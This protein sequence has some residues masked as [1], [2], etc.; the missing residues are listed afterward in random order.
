MHLDVT[1]AVALV[2]ARERASSLMHARMAIAQ[3][4]TLC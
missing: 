4:I 2:I 1:H 3:C